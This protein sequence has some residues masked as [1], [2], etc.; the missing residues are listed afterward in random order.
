MMAKQKD[1]D[2][3]K[4]NKIDKMKKGKDGTFLD[5][6]TY[7]NWY[8][9]WNRNIDTPLPEPVSVPSFRSAFINAMNPS[10]EQAWRAG[11]NL[12]PEQTR[13]YTPTQVNMRDTDPF[14][15]DYWDES[16]GVG[17]IPRQQ[18]TGIG[19]VIPDIVQ[20][21]PTQQAPVQAAPQRQVVSAPALVGSRSSFAPS[22]AP[23][24]EGVKLYS[25]NPFARNFNPQAWFGNNPDLLSVFGE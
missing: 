14:A 1:Y 5:Y 13:A 2:Y 11:A 17:S 6:E 8:D 15:A 12:P 19:R 16:Q 4:F 7:N 20:Q 22:G 10:Y 23:S 3:A 25:A 9:N 21:V 24:L 18:T